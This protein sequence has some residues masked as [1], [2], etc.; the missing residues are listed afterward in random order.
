MTILKN[1]FELPKIAFSKGFNPYFGQKMPIFFVYVDL[2]RIRLKIM[3]SDFA[4]E[5]DTFLTIKDRK[6]AFIQRD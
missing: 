6:F 2:E 3:L 4:Q 1:F 5:K